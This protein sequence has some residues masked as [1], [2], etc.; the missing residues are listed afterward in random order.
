MVI[1]LPIESV[2]TIILTITGAI[3]AWIAYLHTNVEN[4]KIQIA[5]ISL[6][7]T[8]LWNFQ[9]RRRALE[10]LDNGIATK[11]SPLSI[12][13]NILEAAKELEKPLREFF[14]KLGRPD[15]SNADL[16]FHLELYFGDQIVDKI[17]IPNNV[18]H[19]A[20]M[21]IAI[22]LATNNYIVDV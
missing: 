11:N 4:I 9:L 2:T 21:I 14:A 8:T 1:S 18:A 12:N 22:A 3:I 13:A 20:C 5:Q 16:A 15:I 19:G 17:C 6:Q 10:A 7:N